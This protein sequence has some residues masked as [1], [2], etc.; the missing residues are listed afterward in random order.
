M[1]ALAALLAGLSVPRAIDLN[2]TKRGFE[3][4]RI[5]VRKDEPVRLVVTRKTDQTCAKEIAIPD[6]HVREKL[7]LDQPVAIE[8]TPRKAG[9]LRFACGM[10][11]VSGVL[12]V[13]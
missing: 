3:P 9:E 2:V 12:V 6:A 4:S 13:E 7:P 11:M 8:F 10:D 1:F 5:S